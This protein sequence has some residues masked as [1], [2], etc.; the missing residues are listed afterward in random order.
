M[1]PPPPAFRAAAGKFT[2][3]FY[4]LAESEF[5]QFRQ[6]FPE[7]LRWPDAVLFEAQAALKQQKLPAAIGLLTAQMP[8]AGDRADQYRYWL[9]E[10]HLRGSN[11]LAAAESFALLARDYTNSARLLEASY[12]EAKARFQLR[13]WKR[14]VDLPPPYEIDYGF[15]GTKT[16]A[17]GAGWRDVP[18][19]MQADNMESAAASPHWL[20]GRC[21]CC[22]GGW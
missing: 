13:D 15:G 14:A 6:N 19:R 5:A 22:I 21:P 10:T 20:G 8:K 9:A 16:S 3:G 11:Y 4:E 12:G 18:L 1:R 7:S 2:D 17:L